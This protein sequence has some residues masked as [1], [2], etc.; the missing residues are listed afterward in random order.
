M[1]Q[2]PQISPLLIIGNGRL[3]KHLQHYYSLLGF[4]TYHWHRGHRQSAQ[5]PPLHPQPEPELQSQPQTQAP[6]QSY[7]QDLQ[8]L[9]AKVDRVGLLISDRAIGTF[10]QEHFDALKNKLV[11]HCSGALCHPLIESAHPL[12][13]FS[14][15]LYTEDQYRQITFVLERGRAQFQDIFPELPNLH[16][17]IES[18]N[19]ALYHALCV[20]A[21]NLTTLLQQDAL[22]EF[23]NLNIPQPAV[24]AFV[25]QTIS[26]FFEQPRTSLTGPLARKDVSTIQANLESLKGTRLQGVYQQFVTWFPE[27]QDKIGG[28]KNEH[29][30]FSEL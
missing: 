21:G 23:E 13:T 26:N 25:R 17:D 12:M 11:F 10:Y 29:S 4:Q 1:G 18:K 24:E 2:V 15:A 3:A 16:V 27:I 8:S 19:K 28:K 5:Q 20:C 30:R 6:A 7:A 9:L 22:K 14:E